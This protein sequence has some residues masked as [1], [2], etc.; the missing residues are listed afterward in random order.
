ML[1]YNV[2]YRNI[3]LKLFNNMQSLLKFT[4][5]ISTKLQRSNIKFKYFLKSLRDVSTVS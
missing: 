4:K 1:K 2:Y 3:I 5:N